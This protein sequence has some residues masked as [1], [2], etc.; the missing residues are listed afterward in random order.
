MYNDVDEY[1]DEY[2]EMYDEIYDEM[3]DDDG[4]VEEPVQNEDPSDGD[5]HDGRDEGRRH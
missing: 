5:P 1:D 4:G 3:Y 2:G